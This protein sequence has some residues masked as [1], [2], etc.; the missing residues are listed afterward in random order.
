MKGPYPY[1]GASGIVDYINDYIFEGEHVLI[2]EDGENLRSRQTPIAFKVNGKFWVN[3]HAHI[4][5]GKDM[6]INDYI[7]YYFQNLNINPYIT[8]AVQPKL[9]LDNL[10][11]IPI[12]MPERKGR[13]ALTRTLL[14]LDQKIDLLHRQNE[15]LEAIAQTL[16]KRWFVEFEFPN[17]EGQPYKSSGGRMVDSELGEIPE[18]WKVGTLGEIADITTGKGLKREEY[19]KQGLYP[20]L[21]ANGEMG[22]TNNY[23]YDLRLL[24]TGRVGTLGKVFIV[25]EKSWISDNVLIS[26]SIDR[27]FYFTYFM[28]KKINYQSLNRGSTQPLITQTDLKSIELIIPSKAIV[29]KFEL[30]SN[31]HFSKIDNNKNQIKSLNT[32]LDTLLPKLIGGQIRV[33]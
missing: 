26:I 9:N 11:S 17:K 13:I 16:F 29:K 15:T 31:G 7:V 14:S 8:G 21:G 32:I 6:L 1:Y 10:Q 24:I 28:M 12:L 30:F 19:D 23:L 27:F 5:K 3:N 25:S 4:L 22:R 18:G 2:S 20:V 33:K